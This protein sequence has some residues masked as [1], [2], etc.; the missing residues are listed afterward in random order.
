MKEHFKEIGYL[1]VRVALTKKSVPAINLGSILEL[2]LKKDTM[3]HCQLLINRA[4][5]TILGSLKRLKSK[6]L[7]NLHLLNKTM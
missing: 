5:K 1:L 6:L 7:L 2:R 4:K 3:D